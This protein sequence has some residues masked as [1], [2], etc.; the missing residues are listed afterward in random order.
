MTIKHSGDKNCDEFRSFCKIGSEYSGSEV[1]VFVTQYKD[2][3]QTARPKYEVLYTEC[4]YGGP[5]GHRPGRI[6]RN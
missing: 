5:L 2:G 3:V 4:K 1:W 6:A